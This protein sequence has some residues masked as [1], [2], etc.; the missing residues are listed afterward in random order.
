MNTR[1]K[2]LY[3]AGG[4]VLVGLATLGLFLPLLPTTPLLLLAAA[5]FMRSSEKYH[6]W[7]LEH[8]IFGPILRDW[9]DKRCIPRNVKVISV[10]CVVLF[11]TYA[12]G[13][14]IENTYLRV[15]GTAVL[16]VGLIVLLRLKVCEESSFS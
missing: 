16:L 5:C 12:V 9:Q 8:R 11:G 3:L 2:W 14:A 6:R 15:V 13:F 7:L 4:F 10:V 1:V